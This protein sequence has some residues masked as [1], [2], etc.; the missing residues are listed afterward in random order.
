MIPG[1]SIVG[2]KPTTECALFLVH[3][4]GPLARCHSQTIRDALDDNADAFVNIFHYERI[5]LSNLDN[6]ATCFVDAPQ[7]RP[8]GINQIDT[9]THNVVFQSIEGPAVQRL[10]PFPEKLIANLIAVERGMG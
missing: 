1:R 9:D 2:I 6:D 8:I 5:L 10:I 7:E 4:I 3:R